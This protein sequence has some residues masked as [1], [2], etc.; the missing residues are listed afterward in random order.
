MSWGQDRDVHF[1]AHFLMKGE[2]PSVMA[3]KLEFGA[4]TD[5]Y[6]HIYGCEI[7]KQAL[8]DA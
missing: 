6:M 7:S 4:H 5:K 8:R 3:D 2:K 1:S